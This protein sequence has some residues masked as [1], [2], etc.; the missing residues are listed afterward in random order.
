M[1]VW[2]FMV[3]MGQYATLSEHGEEIKKL[4]EDMETARAW[5]E[6]LTQKIEQLEKNE[7]ETN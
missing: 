1:G 5:I 4:K 3:D 6:Y 2:N 7:K